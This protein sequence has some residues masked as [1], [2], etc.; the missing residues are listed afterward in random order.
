[1]LTNSGLCHPVFALAK[2]CRKKKSGEKKLERLKRIIDCPVPNGA[3]LVGV[4]R[5]WMAQKPLVSYR[6]KKFPEA[7]SEYPCGRRFR[8][9]HDVMNE[10]GNFCG[11]ILKINGMKIVPAESKEQECRFYWT[12]LKNCSWGGAV[13]FAG[14]ISR[15]L[16]KPIKHP[17]KHTY[18]MILKQ[19]PRNHGWLQNTFAIP[20]TNHRGSAL[21]MQ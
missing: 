13:H 3:T 14:S 15:S 6:R 19:P 17:R 8:P 2:L 10:C 20:P 21:G 1:M 11:K 5:M 18:T 4:S 16:F 9:D 12:A 7:C